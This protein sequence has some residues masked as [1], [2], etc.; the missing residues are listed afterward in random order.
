MT[1][2]PDEAPQGSPW[3]WKQYALI[4]FGAVALLLILWLARQLGGPG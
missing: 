3:G 1:H 2:P 4:V